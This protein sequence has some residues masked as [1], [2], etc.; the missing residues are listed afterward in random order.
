MPTSFLGQF[1]GESGIGNGEFAAA[2]SASSNALYQAGAQQSQILTP[3]M[4]QQ[5]ILQQ[6]RSAAQFQ[7]EQ[8]RQEVAFMAQWYNTIPVVPK[9][10]K[11]SV[12]SDLSKE[13]DR[14]VEDVDGKLP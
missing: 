3:Q 6:Q 8:N 5:L 13:F 12:H 7:A 14:Y 1:W 2:Q 9:V 10:E 11:L 4:Q